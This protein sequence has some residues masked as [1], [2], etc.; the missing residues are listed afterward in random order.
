MLVRLN[1]FLL[2]RFFRLRWYVWN[3]INFRHL[4]VDFL[5]F[6]PM[7]VRN[8]NSGVHLVLNLGKLL[9]G[10]VRVRFYLRSLI[11]ITFKQH[12]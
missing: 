9:T 3:H 5:G 7:K 2:Y 8:L 10:I 6:F 4:Y 12:L 1:K 11:L